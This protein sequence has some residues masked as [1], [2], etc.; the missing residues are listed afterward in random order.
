MNKFWKWMI[1]NNYC[2][3]EYYDE[4]RDFTSYGNFIPGSKG[5]EFLKTSLIGYMME[6]LLSKKISINKM[7]PLLILQWVGI[8]QCGVYNWL[9]TKI[10]N[11]KE[12]TNE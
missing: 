1:D 12:D 5:I 9:E 6:Y 7:F 8:N 3:T 2:E 11:Y 4:E 10:Q